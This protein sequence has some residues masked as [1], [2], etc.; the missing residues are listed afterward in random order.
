MNAKQVYCREEPLYPIVARTQAVAI[1]AGAAS[2]W[3][4]ALRSQ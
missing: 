3:I 2:T 1:H 4:A